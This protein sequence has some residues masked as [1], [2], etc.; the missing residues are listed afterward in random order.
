MIH[1]REFP[2]SFSPG[3]I[4]LW[5]FVA[6]TTS[7]RRPLSALPTISSDSPPEYTSAVSTKLIPPSIAALM[8]R[9]AS[10]WSWF[11][12]SPNIIVPRQCVLTRMPV[13]PMTRYSMP[14]LPGGRPVMGVAPRPP[15]NPSSRI[16][17]KGMIP[18][19]A[20][21]PADGRAR[22]LRG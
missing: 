19:P 6:S 10:S 4:G 9:A 18:V 17:G 12:H 11:P 20:T 1:S 2:R 8:T 7:S 21:G 3:P 16:P 15:V 5:N 13:P 14:L 22:S